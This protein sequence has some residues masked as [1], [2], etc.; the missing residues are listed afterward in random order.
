MFSFTQN[1]KV[2]ALYFDAENNAIKVCFIEY[3]VLRN[4]NITQTF[5]QFEYY[6]NI[7]Y[8]EWMKN[9]FYKNSDII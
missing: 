6:V 7:F 8:H 1:W 4:V 9:I 3:N 2:M 5:V